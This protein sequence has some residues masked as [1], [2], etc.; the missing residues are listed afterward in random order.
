MHKR[1]GNMSDRLR[2]VGEGWIT[3]VAL[4][5]KRELDMQVGYL[6]REGGGKY[7]GEG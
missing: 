4:F 1:L 2:K 3:L 7:V 5:R 6:E